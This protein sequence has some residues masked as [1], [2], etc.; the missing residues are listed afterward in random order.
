MKK[1]NILFLLLFV[2]PLFVFGQLDEKLKEIDDYANT[3]MTTWKGP[4]MAIGIVKDD[5]LVFAKGYGVRELGKPDKVDENTVFAIASNSKAFTAASLAILVDEKKLSWDDKVSKYLPDFQMYDPWVTNELTIRD[6]V[7]HR[8]GLDTFSGD[9]LW[10]DTT[11]SSDEI[12]HRLRYLKPVSSFRTR[13]GYQNL[14][15]I[16]AGK[17]IEKVS[18][19]PWAEFV[20][21]R[22]LT[23]LGMDRTT[24]SVKDLKDNAAMPH[25][26]SGGKLRVLPHGNVDGAAPPLPST[27]PSLTFPNGFAFNWGA[28]NSTANRYSARHKAGRC[29]SRT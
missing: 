5:K 11:Y 10:Y 26:E 17:V 7:S 20:R 4:G 28:E 3:V 14:M 21:E 2:F 24:T 27:L 8:V 6:L 29:G 12:L 25:N 23:P 19:K 9:L 16:A 1:L 18:G 13:F 22:I 15:F